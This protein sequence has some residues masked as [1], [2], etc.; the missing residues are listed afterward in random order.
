MNSL[1][2]T[3]LRQPITS[4]LIK[5]TTARKMH[6]E[7]IPMWVGS[8]NNYAYLVTDDKTKEAVIIDPA[9]PSEVLPSLKKAT[10]AGS[11]LTNI[12]NTHH[13]HD[14]AGGNVEILKSYP[15]PII[16]GKDCTKV[17]KTPAHN[18]TFNIGSIKVKALHTPCHTQDSVCF[19]FE[20]GDDKA[21]FTGDTLFIGGCGRFFEGSAQEMDTAL[22]KVLGALPDDTKVYPGHEYTAGNVKFGIKVLQ[23]EPVKALEKFTKENKQTQGKFTIGDEKKHNVFMRLDDPEVQKYTG[24]TDRVDVMSALREAKNNM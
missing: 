4:T 10:D 16:G 17:T 23:S 11:K 22:N 5:P 12:I 8:G 2:Q 9:N 14:H 21:V 19:L 20:D 15:L 13:H 7:S 24:K 18:E 1:K 6:I 3:L